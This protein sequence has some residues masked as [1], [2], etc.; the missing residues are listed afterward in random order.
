MSSLLKN[1]YIKV[2]KKKGFL[3]LVIIMFAFSFLTNILYKYIDNEIIDGGIYNNEETYNQAKKEYE[4][5]KKDK[6]TLDWYLSEKN[7]YDVYQFLQ[8][9]DSTAWKYEYILSNSNIY[10][11]VERI[12]SYELK[13]TKDEADYKLAKEE[14][15]KLVQ[16]LKNDDWKQIVKDEKSEKED[17]IKKID[18]VIRLKENLQE[19]PEDLPDDVVDNF[20]IYDFSSDESL[21]SLSIDELKKN[22]KALEIEIEVLDKQLDQNISWADKVKYAQLNEYAMGKVNLL[23]YEGKN[24]D[25]LKKDEKET[26]YEIREQ[27]LKNEFAVEN[28]KYRASISLSTILEEFYSEFLF[29]LVIFIFLIAGPMVSQESNKGTIKLLLVKP[30]SRVKILLSKYIVSLSSVLMAVFIMFI[31]ELLIGGVLFGFSSLSDK[32][33]L[34]S[35]ITDSAQYISIIKYFILNTIAYLPQLIL[36]CTLAFAAS[37]IFNNTAVAIISGFAGYIGSNILTLLLENA[38][39]KPFVKYFIGF[40]WNFSSYIFNKPV[41]FKGLTFGFSL[42]VCIIYLLVLIIPA[43]I[44]FK[45][46]DIKNV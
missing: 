12:N 45:K 22:K 32:I 4:L 34:Y 33:V 39:N 44:V 9:Y 29:I 31:F 5:N 21:T 43:F 27:Y 20:D 1:E 18:E 3:I 23:N 6:Q 11:I 25:K 15:D 8:N 40:N 41:S 26:Y 30:Y 37:S 16:L 7:Q 46:R 13:V 38:V 17:N 28:N 19:H 24:I 2:F 42:M 35:R 10:E 36:L 14:Y